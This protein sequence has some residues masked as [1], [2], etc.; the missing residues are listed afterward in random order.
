MNTDAL[1]KGLAAHDLA[2]ARSLWR[3]E[4]HWPLS[5]L[6]ENDRLSVNAF[7]LL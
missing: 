7:C 6:V 1:V 3:G 4:H 5:P 2:M